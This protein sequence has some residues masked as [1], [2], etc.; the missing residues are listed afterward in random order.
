MLKMCAICVYTNSQ[1]FPKTGSW[2]ADFVCGKRSRFSSTL[3]SV[4]YVLRSRFQVTELL[5]HWTPNTIVKWIDVRAIWWHGVFVSKV[6]TVSCKPL[7]SQFCC[8]LENKPL[9]KQMVTVVQWF[10]QQ[11]VYVII[12]MDLCFFV[13]EV[14][15][16]FTIEADACRNHDMRPAR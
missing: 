10:W 5:K 7:L 15:A 2:L 8:M 13:N 6:W 12:C 14:Q 9:A 16:F 3:T 4:R 11:L 1:T